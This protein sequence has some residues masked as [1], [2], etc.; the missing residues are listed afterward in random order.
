MVE[1]C[2]ICGTPDTEM[3]LEPRGHGEGWLMCV[4][5]CKPWQGPRRR[6]YAEVSASTLD[7]LEYEAD[8]AQSI[9]M[10]VEVPSEVLHS[11]IRLARQS[12]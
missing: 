5:E 9:C 10:P 4:G 7:Q 11:L 1:I 8:E 3:Q 12:V 6:K 2:E